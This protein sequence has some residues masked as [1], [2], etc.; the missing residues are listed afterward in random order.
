MDLRKDVASTGIMPMPKPSEQVFGGHA[1]L[2]VGYDDAKKVLI[3]RN[4]WGSGWGDK[5]YFYMP[6][7]NMKYNHDF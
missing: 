7:D 3:V 6:Y 4:S 1:V 2:A 5:G